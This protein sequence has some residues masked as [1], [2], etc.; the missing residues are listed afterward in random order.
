MPEESDHPVWEMPTDPRAREE[1]SVTACDPK[2][3][4]CPCCLHEEEDPAVLAENAGF[5]AD[6][7]SEQEEPAAD[8]W[9][10]DFGA[11]GLSVR[12]HQASP[13][14]TLRKRNPEG[15]E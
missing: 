13:G 4:T 9:P 3:E 1:N 15:L 7:Y 5:T 12:A 11:E 8:A 14:G 2:P 10:W 6:S